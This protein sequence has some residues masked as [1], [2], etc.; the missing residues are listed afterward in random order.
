V[1]DIFPS[2]LRTGKYKP[3]ISRST[4]S[5][6]MDVGAPSNFERMSDIY[7]N[8]LNAFKADISACSF[9]DQQTRNMMRSVLYKYNY[10][11]DP[12]GAIAYMGLMNYIGDIGNAKAIFLETAHPSKFI[13]VMEETLERKIELPE[14][15]KKALS[16]TKNVTTISKNFEDLK[17]YLLNGS[18]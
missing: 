15:L 4:I 13:D 2:Y 10:M 12:H 1:N 17:A 16:G 11:L 6:A 3:K 8:S 18:F 7:D 9:T 5:N 14:E